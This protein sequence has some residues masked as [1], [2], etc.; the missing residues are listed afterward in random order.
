MGKMNAALKVITLDK[1]IRAYLE[2]HDPMALKQCLEALDGMTTEVEIPINQAR[3]EDLIC[4]AFEC[5]YCSFGIKRYEYPEGQTKQ[6]L[7]IEY[8][9]I[10]LP[11]KG[12]TIVLDVPEDDDGKEYRLDKEACIRGLK[13]MAEK[14]PK[15]YADWFTENDDAIT[16]DVYLQCCV[17][18]DI[19]YG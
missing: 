16:A 1:N 18:G 10:Q 19:V 14:F 11:F 15:H 3:L 8:Q 5:G 9:H 4:D 13:V 2:Q 6:S 7:G 12:G 17:L